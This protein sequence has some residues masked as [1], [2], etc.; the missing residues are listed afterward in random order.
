MRDG[1]ALSADRCEGA[2]PGDL[3]YRHCVRAIGTITATL[4]TRSPGPLLHPRV[5][6]AGPSLTRVARRVATG[7]WQRCRP[8]AKG[9]PLGFDRLAAA[10]GGIDSE[11]LGASLALEWLE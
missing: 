2:G 7:L 1:A 6:P 3:W 5:R 8:R 10:L 11:S 4:S 9:R